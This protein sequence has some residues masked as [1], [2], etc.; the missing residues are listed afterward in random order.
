[1]N[2]Y[3]RIC[4]IIC[5]SAGRICLLRQDQSIARQYGERDAAIADFRRLHKPKEAMALPASSYQLAPNRLKA[6]GASE[7]KATSKLKR[8]HEP[9]GYL[10]TQKPEERELFRP[11]N[12]LATD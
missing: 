12:L 10:E 5:K 1:M 3:E 6:L 8:T 11:L 2:E 7:G 9:S 4:E